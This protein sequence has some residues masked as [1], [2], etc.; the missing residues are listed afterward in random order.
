MEVVQPMLLHGARYGGIMAGVM[1]VYALFLKLIGAE[2]GISTWGYYLVFPIVL[3]IAMMRFPPAA[4][5]GSSYL[6]VVLSGLSV[7]VIGSFFYCLWVIVNTRWIVKGPIP[8]LV[9][10]YETYQSRADA[11]ENVE[12]ALSS[13]QFFMASP[14]AFAVNVWVKLVIF[15][16][17]LSLILAL[18]FRFIKR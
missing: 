4:A 8:A 13:L 12:R 2:T 16:G 1:I 11:G 5:A 18:V 3:T 17:L 15:G 6:T 7:S 10:Q 9:E 14:E